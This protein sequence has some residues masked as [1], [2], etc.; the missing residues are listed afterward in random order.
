MPHGVAAC[1]NLPAG[2]GAM[3][4]LAH[5]IRNGVLR[6][7]EDT[8]NANAQHW[9]REAMRKALYAALADLPGEETERIIDRACSA[10]EAE[11]E[12]LRRRTDRP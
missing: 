12:D 1:S 5:A 6:M 10:Y 9:S 2:G 11:Q 8:C 7:V 3:D 4:A